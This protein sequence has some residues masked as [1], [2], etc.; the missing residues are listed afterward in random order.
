MSDMGDDFKMLKDHS[1]E[2]RKANLEWSTVKVEEFL[3]KNDINYEIK[4]DGQHF[5][6]DNEWDYWPSGGLFIN[7]KTKKKSRG[8]NNLIA[9]IKKVKGL[10]VH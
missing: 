9:A 10:N 4:N 6:I 2:K 3:K 8:M 5:I 7:R 1:K